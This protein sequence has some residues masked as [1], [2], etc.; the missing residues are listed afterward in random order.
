MKR[1]GYQIQN[2]CHFAAKQCENTCQS[3]S[4]KDSCTGEPK[5]YKI[6]M[7]GKSADCPTL[8]GSCSNYWDNKGDKLL[9]N[10]LNKK[11]KVDALTQ[12]GY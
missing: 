10:A 4:F 11:V 3:S 5:D 6:I 8:R 12:K 1:N 2:I 9:D 7:D